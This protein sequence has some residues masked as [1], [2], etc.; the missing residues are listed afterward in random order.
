M[1]ALGH[2]IDRESCGSSAW[3][4]LPGDLLAAFQYLKGAYWKAGEGLGHMATGQ[5][6]M[7]LYWKKVDLD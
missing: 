3:R 1:S 2:M 5:R 6:E 7:A 4:R